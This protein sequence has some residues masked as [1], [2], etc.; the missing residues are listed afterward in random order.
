M[1]IAQTP[2]VHQKQTQEFIITWRAL[3]DNYQLEEKPVD[4]TGQ[5]LL[6]GAL[7][8]SLALSGYLQP[9]MLIATNFGLCAT[10]N[11]K[12]VLKAPDWVYVAKVFPPKTL[13]SDRKSYTPHLE[14]EVPT[15]VMEF[16]SDTDGVEYSVKSTYPPGKWFFYEHFY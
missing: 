5:P 6:A 8:E 13:G 12:L 15:I 7:R 16:L 11:E 3:P 2:P 9:E 10:I 4:N 1:T 14:G